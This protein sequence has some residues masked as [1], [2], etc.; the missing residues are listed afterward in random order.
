MVEVLTAVKV[1]PSHHGWTPGNL[2]HWCVRRLEDSLA[3]LAPVR[4]PLWLTRRRGRRAGLR[5]CREVG[6]ELSGDGAGG[7]VDGGEGFD[8]QRRFRLKGVAV[9]V[10]GVVER[11][12]SKV[13]P[14]GT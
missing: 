4:M 11:C 13:G 10:G 9:E 12:Q 6:Q 3:V 8:G 1:A 5:W 7:A 14:P 2:T